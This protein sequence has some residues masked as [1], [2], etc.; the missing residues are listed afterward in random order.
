MMAFY[1]T[2]AGLIG[3]TPLVRLKR[4]EAQ[5]QLS[6]RL[7]AKLEGCQIGGSSKTRAV[8]F[9]LDDAVKQGRLH[10]D[11][12]IIEASSGNTGIALAL[13]A[14]RRGIR[15]IIVMPEHMSRERQQLIR[16]YGAELIL[17]DAASGMAGAMKTAEELLQSTP[18]SLSLG[19]FEN[20]ANPRA[21]YCTTAPELWRDSGGHLQVFVAG[22]GSGGTISGVGRYLKERNPHIRIVA[23]EPAEAPVLSGGAAGRHKL[24]GIGAGFVP[25]TLDRR[26]IDCIHPVCGED[27]TAAAA[28][29]AQKEGLLCG[30]SG[31]AALHAAVE[32]AKK[33]RRGE[34]VAVL[35]PDSGERYL[36]D[37]LYG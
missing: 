3:H 24:Q 15:A 28:L 21:H 5:Y 2:P 9:M 11:S 29:L 26:V 32:I 6:C 7:L 12:T 33:C 1:P 34:S 30:F 31:G 27:A 14:A 13:L 17:T 4:M 8:K 19:Q 10:Q 25:N 16:A 23:V 22:V 18:A 35:L 37:A 36:S 20:S